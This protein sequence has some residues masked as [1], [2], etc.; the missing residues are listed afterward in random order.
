MNRP[1]TVGVIG[2]MG[3]AATAEFFRRL[4]AAT[5]ARRDDEHLRVLIDSDPR[6]PGRTAAILHGGPD[7]A[8]RLREIARGLEAAG[9]ELLAMPCNTAHA[10]LDA[11]RDAVAI[12]V[13]DMLEEATAKIGKGPVGLLATA[14]TVRLGLYQDVGRR[15]GLEVLVPDADRQ[16]DVTRVIAALKARP[17]PEALRK[18]LG[19]VV[20]AL[21]AS[22][23]RG[24]TNP[25][26]GSTRST[27]WSRP[28]FATR[29]RDVGTRLG[30]EG[31]R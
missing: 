31:V 11:I 24:S 23:A 26:C 10:Y 16:A 5:P 27:P 8:P 6:I 29:S 20:G 22:G 7:P 17:T 25:S 4:I 9:A 14:A 2:G 28:R 12:P 19:C 18:D 1:K 13:L 15:R 30:E 3:P 21:K